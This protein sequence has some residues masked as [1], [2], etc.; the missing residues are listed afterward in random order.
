MESHKS[1]IRSEKSDKLKM[2]ERS[3]FGEEPD[4]SSLG[5]MADMQQATILPASQ[6]SKFVK[7]R[8]KP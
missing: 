7:R 1:Y 2:W 3:H 5:S 6:F 4:K 8:I